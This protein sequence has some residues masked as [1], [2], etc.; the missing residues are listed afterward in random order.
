M[1]VAK[2]EINTPTQFYISSVEFAQPKTRNNSIIFA[3]FIKSEGIDT[4]VNV[5]DFPSK[6]NMIKF[7][8]NSGVKKVIQ[9][10]LKDVLISKAQYPAL[11]HILNQ[12]CSGL[13]RRVLVHCTAG[14]NRSALVISHCI[15][16]M[17]V[18][19]AYEIINI[20]RYTNEK[21]RNT[22]ALINPTFVTFLKN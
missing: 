9:Y 17:S 2:I 16:K 10:P 12:I 13:G 3:N 8:K 11:L 5:S 1:D 7:Y 21:Y 19:N 4:I 18:L 20:I 22:P 15:M 6:P 14:I